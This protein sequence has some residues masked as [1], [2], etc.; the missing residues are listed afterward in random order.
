MRTRRYS[1]QAAALTD[2]P[3][4]RARRSLV[5]ASLAGLTLAACG[6]R[7]RGSVRLPFANLFVQAPANTPLGQEL[8]RAL[9]ASDVPL[10][11]TQAKAAATLTILS[12]LRERD[13]L[14]LG[15]TGRV[16]EYQLRYRLAYQVSD[17]KGAIITPPSEIVLKRDL[18]YSD[19]E[20]L[21]KESEVTL[22]YR[23]MQTDAVQQLLRRLQAIKLAGS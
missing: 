19:E 7:L 2:A 12:E 6:F 22:L 20:A 5:L 1:T 18:S 21:A 11:E 14:S 16:R 17:A 15:G 9:R 3:S 10:E 8:R 23:D 4:S 13:I